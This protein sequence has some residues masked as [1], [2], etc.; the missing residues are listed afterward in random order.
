MNVNSNNVKFLARHALLIVAIL[1]AAQYTNT[2][3]SKEDPVNPDPV[4]AKDYWT[5]IELPTSGP[6][7]FRA[8]WGIG[9]ENFCAVTGGGSLACY[10]G[11]EWNLG[12][13]P[14]FGGNQGTHGL[15]V[16]DNGDIFVASD[17][18][19]MVW[20]EESC[21]DWDAI[22]CWHCVPGQNLP[23]LWEDVWGVKEGDQYYIV[24]VGYVFDYPSAHGFI[25][26]ACGSNLSG[27]AD[28]SEWMFA[29]HG[30]ERSNVFA[31][32]EMATIY[33]TD[34]V[35]WYQVDHG[36]TTTVDFRGV[37]ASPDGKAFVVG[38]EGTIVHYDRSD[39]IVQD[40][41]VNVTL[42]DVWGEATDDVFVVGAAGTAL[43]YDGSEWSTMTT[44]TSKTL[45]SIW[46]TSADNV[47]A[48]GDSTVLHFQGFG[49]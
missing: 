9:E 32:G 13:A 49:R 11:S 30:T 29:V 18:D 26:P 22:G 27:S 17:E 44:G 23:F 28:P 2:G 6:Y 5:R 20:Y 38:H 39:W 31:V 43:H 10:D 15:W 35:G 12:S 48:V 46:G 41:G 14:V 19:Y 37:W 25:S 3:C 21:G 16:K 8:I 24:G 45:W 1:A 4:P 36:L 34:R 47:Y 40:S 33:R 7:S 42:H